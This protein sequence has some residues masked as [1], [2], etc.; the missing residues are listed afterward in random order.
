MESLNDFEFSNMLLRLC[1]E[2][3]LRDDI[4]LDSGIVSFYKNC[5]AKAVTS[6][7]PAYRSRLEQGFPEYSLEPQAPQ[8][9]QEDTEEDL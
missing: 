4:P 3:A 9:V 1:T 8:F 5:L 7:L 6:Q 2:K